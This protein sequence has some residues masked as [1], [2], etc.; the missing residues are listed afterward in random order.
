MFIINGG[1]S[2]VFDRVTQAPGTSIGLTMIGPGLTQLRAA[3]NSG[4]YLTNRWDITGQITVVR[5]PDLTN[6]RMFVFNSILPY[7]AGLPNLQLDGTLIHQHNSNLLILN[8]I[9]SAFDTALIQRSAQGGTEIA[10][11]ANGQDGSWAGR[12]NP[13][14]NNPATL[15]QIYK[16]GNGVQVMS[17]GTSN[18]GRTTLVEGVL[19]VDS[20]ADQGGTSAL[21]GGT[22]TFDGGSLR[23][24]GAGHTANREI[25]V[26]FRGG[27]LEA[28]GSGAL[29]LS[30][31]V[32]ATDT[33]WSVGDNTNSG[34][35]QFV[36]NM[37]GI[38][39]LGALAAA[40]S[41]QITQQG[42][43]ISG[44][45]GTLPVSID[46]TSRVLELAPGA[47]NNTPGNGAGQPRLVFTSTS[48]LARTLSLS[49]TS[50][51]DNT[52][53]GNLADSG[54]GGTLNLTK[55]G[56]G[57]W[58]LSGANT[59]TGTT[60]VNGGSLQLNLNAHAPI[61][62]GTASTSFADI[63]AGSLVLD[64]NGGSSVAATV[65][66]ILDAG[67]DLPTQFSDGQIRSSTANTAI[68]LGWKEDLVG[69]Q[70][71]VKRTYYG[72]VDLDG[73]VDVA[74]LGVLATNWQGSGNWSAADFDYSGSINVN[75]LGRLASNWQAGVGNPLGPDFASAAAALGLPSSAVPEPAGLVSMLPALWPLRRA[76]RR[77]ITCSQ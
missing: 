57:K 21:G 65:L 76:R 3:T 59:Y 58:I 40:G 53:A 17:N 37:Y 48:P 16:I 45:T 15:D 72:D 11:G 62:P 12:F 8:A 36:T 31:P 5:N 50:A 70:V 35:S 23:Y 52:V 6:S 69:Q 14:T 67:Y 7:G 64:Y 74:D 73:K 47:T 43:G 30:G 44:A 26:G 25:Q 1:P 20:I 13:S 34:P 51:A 24:T 61:L 22:I 19:S 29:V 46:E 27:T 9:D 54:Q 10:I 42:T 77:P 32:A 75:D 38:K 4:N 55:T 33:A 18:Y 63:K 66:G 41:L 56:T 39:G 71:V 49:G 60:V 28:S 2:I 68:G